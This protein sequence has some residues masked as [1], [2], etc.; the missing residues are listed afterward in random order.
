MGDVGK[1]TLTRGRIGLRRTMTE[2]RADSDFLERVDRTMSII[3]RCDVVTPVEDRGDPATQ[4][5]DRA[6]QRSDIIV[7]GQKAGAHIAMHDPV[8]I[9]TSP[10]TADRPQPRLPGVQM[11]IDQA[12][13]N[14]LVAGVDHLV[15]VCRDVRPHFR[16]PVPDYQEVAIIEITECWIDRDDP[17]IADERPLHAK[18]AVS[19]RNGRRRRPRVPHRRRGHR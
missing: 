2:Y 17:A 7:I 9:R 11:G 4:L 1:G 18:P 16:D 12:G 3:E 19:A 13:D 8:V 6:E 10:T 14:D 5:F 15:D